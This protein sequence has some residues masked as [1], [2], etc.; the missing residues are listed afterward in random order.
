M[1]TLLLTYIAGLVLVGLVSLVRMFT[2]HAVQRRELALLI[3]FPV[4][5]PVPVVVWVVFGLAVMS[6]GGLE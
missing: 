1:S 5:W 3:L 4:I 2:T 6:K